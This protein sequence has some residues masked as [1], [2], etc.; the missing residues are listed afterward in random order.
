MY[1]RIHRMRMQFQELRIPEIRIQC[2]SHE[3]IFT[4][5]KVMRIHHTRLL[6]MRVLVI[7]KGTFLIDG[8]FG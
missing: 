7:I 2:L 4:R 5:I 6:E 8:Y 1:I 3:K